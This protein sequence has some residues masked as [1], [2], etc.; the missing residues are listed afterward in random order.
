MLLPGN[1]MTQNQTE[2]NIYKSLAF[3]DFVIILEI[4]CSILILES[5]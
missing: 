4:A 1:L 3:G 5:R 2:I